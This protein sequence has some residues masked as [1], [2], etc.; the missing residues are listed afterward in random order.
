MKNKNV[1]SILGWPILLWIGQF[2]I[3][4]LIGTIYYLCTNDSANFSNFINHH[5]Y[6]VIILEFL[7]FFPILRKHNFLKEGKITYQCIL[8]TILLGLLISIPLNIILMILK[9]QVYTELNVSIYFFTAI[10]TII[11]GPILEELIFRGIVFEKLK[12]KYSIKSSK[13]ITTILFSVS[14]GNVFSIINAFIN[15]YVL[16]SLY[17]KYKNIYIPIIYHITINFVG[18]ILIPVIYQLWF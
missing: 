5:A 14:H 11:V 6:L 13:W 3:V 7:L 12:E 17:D 16:V 4:A 2:F 9:L 15:G 1:F 10:N 8:K 18:T